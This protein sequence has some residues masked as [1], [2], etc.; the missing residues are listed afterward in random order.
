MT[1]EAADAIAS[2]PPAMHSRHEPAFFRVD[3]TAHAGGT[4]RIGTI[5]IGTQPPRTVDAPTGEQHHMCR[6]FDVVSFD[7][8]Y[9]DPPINCGTFGGP[10]R[11]RLGQPDE[12]EGCE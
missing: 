6:C 1:P 2:A 9:Q 12:I 11:P 7:D 3:V 5:R 4:I 8:G 10:P